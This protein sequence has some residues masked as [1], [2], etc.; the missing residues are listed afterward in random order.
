M[1]T[2]LS[3]AIVR[4]LLKP[5]LERGQQ[6]QYG[7]QGKLL[8]VKLMPSGRLGFGG[9]RRGMPQDKEP[10]TNSEHA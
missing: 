6:S 9:R 4:T 5:P 3:D 7:D 8:A 10:S 1:I 2:H